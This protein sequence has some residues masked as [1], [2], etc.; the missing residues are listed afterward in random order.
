MSIRRMFLGL[1]VIGIFAINFSVA[2]DPD[3]WWHLKTGEYILSNG[4]PDTDPGFS[5]SANDNPWFM[6]EWLSDVIMFV[7]YDMSGF[8][9]L[10]ILFNIIA[11]STFLLL[12]FSAS[13]RPYTAAIW[14]LWGAMASS[15]FIG[16]RPQMFN[17]LLASWFVFV[18][19]NYRAGNL[20]KNWLW[21]FVPLMTLWANLHSG[22]LTG[23]VILGVYGLGGI[24][25]IWAS[26]TLVDNRDFTPAQIRHM[27]IVGITMAF[28]SLINPKL[29]EVWLYPFETTLFNEAMQS[30]IEEWF[31]PDFHNYIYWFFGSYFLVGM[32]VLIYSKERLT[33]TE[34]LLVFGSSASSFQSVRNIPIFVIV[35]IPVLT[36]HMV[37]IMQGTSFYG[38]AS[39]TLPDPKISRR[40]AQLNVVFFV[41]V[42]LLAVF[43]VGQEIDGRDAKIA[44]NYPV[45]ALAYVKAQGLDSQNGFNQYGWGG[46]LIW[47]DVPVVIDGRA[48]LYGSDFIT[49]FANAI[50]G[51]RG[52]QAFLDEQAIDY[53]FIDKANPLMTVLETSSDWVL[54]YDDEQAV[55][56]VP[57]DSKLAPKFG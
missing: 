55:I 40:M 20:N 56:F 24:L 52:W 45:E 3:M 8:T 17:L 53:I 6:H 16:V 23:V 51:G 9:G 33:W 49:K 43:W 30:F 42:L 44:D 2:R 11:G 18:L 25:Q 26:K 22:F 37:S 28:A 57:S 31:S 36:R 34:F 29:Y 38:L 5:F 14:V 12:Y 41:V 54:V 39:G 7:V 46:Y 10:S 50:R 27:I 19:E 21:S 13:G 32:A 47:H 35:S 15:F 4:I 48:D 1:I